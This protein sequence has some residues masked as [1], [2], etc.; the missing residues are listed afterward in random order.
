MRIH[1]LCPPASLEPPLIRPRHAP[2]FTAIVAGG[3]RDA[4]H[5][6]SL[7]DQHVKACSLEVIVS[8][9]VSA[10]PELIL[11]MHSDYNRK[12]EESIL[13]RVAAALAT[14]LPDVPLWGFGRLDREHAVAAAEAIPSLH[15]LLFDEP[16]FPAVALATLLEAGEST[17]S[18]PGAVQQLGEELSVVEPERVDMDRTPIP[19]WDL[20]HPSHYG[21]SPHQQGEDTVFP[22]L[23]SR[24]CPF[25]CFYCEVRV[26]PPWRT[27]SVDA[28]LEELST[29]QARYG[30]RSVFLADPT[31]A[32]QKDWAMEFCR[33]VQSEGPR[34]LRWSCM[35]RTDRV[36]PELT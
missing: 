2:H 5:E 31:F 7:A 20:A 29:L 16:E 19:A 23:A 32:I 17:D 27:R 11:L 34:G 10:H 15:G 4:G 35:S 26:R 21:F 36:D 14:A 33:R 28:V 9:T 3:L 22:V 30:M 8:E 1:L 18:L 24:G 25:P 12:L 13:E 6:V